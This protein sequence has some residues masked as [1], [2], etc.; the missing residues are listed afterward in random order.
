M[1]IGKLLTAIVLSL[2]VVATDAQ[3]FKV[4]YVEKISLPDNKATK[5]TAISPTGDYVLLTTPDNTG[6]VKLDL[7]TNNLTSVTS[8]T[9]AGYAPIVSTDGQSIIYRLTTYNSQN[10]RL[11]SLVLHDM[12][13]GKDSVLVNSTHNLQTTAYTDGTVTA[14]ADGKTWSLTFD[15]VKRQT[16]HSRPSLYIDNR[17]L[18]ITENGSTRVFSPNGTDVSYIWPS[19]S[20]DGSKALYYVCGDGA[21]ICD[22]NGENIKRLGHYT[23]PKWYNDNIIVAMDDHDNGQVI[24]SSAIVAVTIDGSMQRLT[25]PDLVAIYPQPS[26]RAGKIAFSTP[27]AQTYLINVDC[28][29]NHLNN[30]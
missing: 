1:T 12:T 18:M 25:S 11:T 26:P 7:R 15:K 24:T 29:N 19:V 9:G 17:R 4:A 28:K 5:I 3:V 22:I 6:L 8:A 2:S 13:T 20:P 10:K 30:P 14:M 27:S 23:A 16:G 21:Y